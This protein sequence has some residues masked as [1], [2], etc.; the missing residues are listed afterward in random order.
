MGWNTNCSSTLRTIGW[1]RKPAPSRRR[2]RGLGALDALLPGRPRAAL[3]VCRPVMNDATQSG[4]GPPPS[5]GEQMADRRVVRMTGCSTAPRISLSSYRPN[6]AEIHIQPAGGHDRDHARWG[7]CAG[8]SAE[9]RVVDR[10]FTGGGQDYLARGG[11]RFWLECR[12]ATPQYASRK[13]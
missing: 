6:M 9:N 7:R 5:R 10:I 2:R 11:A 12:N 4:F 8:A 3:P 13:V 1:S